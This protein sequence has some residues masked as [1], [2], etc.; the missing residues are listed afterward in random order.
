MSR[1]TMFALV[2]ILLTG[3]VLPAS[4]L[5][6][7]GPRAVLP[8]DGIW[9]ALPIKGIDFTY[10][11][12]QQG[13]QTEVVPNPKGR[14]RFIKQKYSAT[15]TVRDLLN[16]DQTAYKQQDKTA[17]WFRRR[18]SLP[19]GSLQGRR[20]ILKFGGM[21]FRTQTW[22]NGK[23]LGTSYM[24]LTPFSYDVTD[25]IKPDTENEIVIGLASQEAFLD[26]KNKTL[27]APISGVYSG[28]WGHV[29]LHLVPRVAIDDVFVKTS[30][31]HKR[32][33]F[34][35]TITNTGKINFA[36]GLMVTIRDQH[37]RPVC[38]VP[39]RQINITP[40]GKKRTI[41]EKDWI[42]PKLWS[43]ETP[44]LYFAT[45]QITRDR[46]IVDK[47]QIRFGFREFEIRGKDFYLNNTRVT[48]LRGSCLA[49]L[50][51][52]WQQGVRD[53][54]QKLAGPFNCIR[55]HIGYNARSLLDAADE[56]GMMTIPESGWHNTAPRPP[57]YG[58]F[59]F[60]KSDLWLP[61]LIAYQKALIREHRNRPSVIMWSLTNETFWH[62]TDNSPE[63][64][65]V[66]EALLAAA[67]KADPTRP[68]QADGDNHWGGRLPTITIHYPLPAAGKL[69][70]KFPN[71]GMVIPNDIDW[72]TDKGVNHAWRAI[73]KWDRPLVIGEYW[74]IGTAGAGADPLSPLMGEAAYDWERWRFQDIQGRDGQPDCG[75]AGV[76][77]M[78]TDYYR[79]RGVAG[80]NPWSADRSL[81]MP[82]LAVRPLEFYPNFFAGDTARRK[83]VVF[84]DTLKNYDYMN[85]QC[86]LT[87]GGRSVWKR[88]IKQNTAPGTH[89]VIEI[90]I[91]VPHTTQP[92]TATLSVRLR[93]WWSGGFHQLSRFEQAIHIM[94]R[95]S[96]ADMTG[97]PITLFDLTGTTANAFS[98]LG[99]V[100]K[101]VTALNTDI[102]QKTRLLIIGANSLQRSQ[103]NVIQAFAEHGGRVL[104]LRQDQWTPVT[105]DLP[106]NDPKHMASR[107]WICAAHPVLA[108]LDN[109]QFSF[110]QPDNLVCRKTFHKPGVGR[111]RLLL[112][113]GGRY[114][115]KWSPLI[116]VPVGK[117]M[118]LLSQLNLTDRI[119]R[120][121]MA[122]ELLG[123]MLR[124]CLSFQTKVLLPLRLLCTENKSLTGC[125]RACS[126]ITEPGLG[127]SGPVLLDASYTPTAD[128]I[129]TLKERL[130][131]GGYVWLHGF[132]PETIGR[133]A[134]LFPFK[135][136]LT[137]FD[138][139]IQAAARR[140]RDPLLN[141]LSTYDFF[142]TKINIGAR[143]DYFQNARPTARL[144]THALQLPSLQA[145]EALT[146]PALLV[147]I[148][149]GKGTILFDG[150]AWEQALGAETDKVSRIVASLVHNM[151]G[152]V[153][154]EQEQ[155]YQ[156]FHVDISKVANM[157]F[158][159]RVAGDNKGG[160]TDQG[161][162]DM[163]YFLINHTGLGEGGM[164]MA[165]AEF[166]AMARFAGRPFALIDPKKSND[167][168]VITLR[169]GPH[170][171]FLP[172]SV[173][174]IMVEQKADKLWFLHT[175]CW[176]PAG[177]LDRVVARYVVHYRDG[178]TVTIPI[179]LEKELSDWWNPKPLPG[180]KVGWSGRNGA[181]APIG[182]YV[183]PWQNPHPDKQ[184]KSL[185][186]VGNLTD[187]QVVIVGITGGV[188]AEHALSTWN[189][190]T[191][192][193]GV[194]TNTVP[195]MTN[196]LVDRRYA[197]PVPAQIRGRKCLRFR[198]GA[199]LIAKT[200]N[201]P[202]ISK[203][204]P[205]MVQIDF[206]M[207]AIPSGHF[208][209]LLQCMRYKHSGF[210]LQVRRHDLRLAVEVF[211]TRAKPVYL[212]SKAILQI[213]R[214][215]RA[216]ISFVAGQASM[217][218]DGKLET[219]ALTSL[220][221]ACPEPM[222]IGVSS[223]K[224]Y[225]FNG[226]I[227]AVQI[228]PGDQNNNRPGSNEAGPR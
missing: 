56:M 191:F 119:R 50:G 46:S 218:L 16:A 201:L 116:E 211:P 126:V 169:G 132:D 111:Y 94:P 170:G 184:I 127:K 138:K 78:I 178:T 180:S 175:A 152:L 73:F 11:P 227:G 17:V 146:T 188:L 163:R 88:I 131:K 161:R 124:Y 83:V 156:Y 183:T 213:G 102:L 203:G 42:A 208:G 13:W 206:L 196:L 114:G 29:E 148:P 33:S 81:I 189:M 117:G 179:R 99:L 59:D 57:G 28:I 134:G 27:L 194:V 55:L 93:A 212:I 40:G 70:K 66:A 15:L 155:P 19:P 217:Y 219:V 52:N 62:E 30:V 6:P 109:R 199:R 74:C 49:T 187:T 80:I 182:L 41:L 174:D 84:N 14:T 130:A 87:I 75:W 145:G 79:I 209:G 205:F 112:D 221:A 165:D 60:S 222:Q 160:W 77:K 158:Y 181:H 85:L 38:L 129:T 21:A 115:M 64:I 22:L 51:Y 133:V 104:V 100:L 135:P 18:F 32:I 171:V 202:A 173:R 113:C 37:G 118:F 140:S 5:I 141:N 1:N 39:A 120:E 82:R 139:S 101:P 110:W 123:R 192:S 153:R 176:A 68:Q 23:M 200:G 149:C 8:L 142:W 157:G 89:S 154:V 122:G 44:A 198:D 20:V 125:L 167:H 166:P 136:R 34:E 69:T 144:G 43:P 197:A 9:Q 150:L 151:G 71:S 121:P 224:D 215:Y 12:P 54:K 106:D 36:G 61:N 98:A 24:A 3:A 214:W 86:R 177:A 63:R 143:K 103:A 216:R 223:G 45:A 128:E 185:D 107:S 225:F 97:R 35:V 159:D 220:P 90:P 91:Q 53:L 105:A 48:L 172:G 204:L 10:P 26:I 228:L 190:S 65:Q 67:R 31:K 72:L 137:E 25:T 58:K 2:Y 164:D 186:L 210:R 7:D 92:L 147:K 76:L 47:Q 162:N 96:L 168:S 95:A 195:G 226:G 108:G 207:E 193:N 4:D